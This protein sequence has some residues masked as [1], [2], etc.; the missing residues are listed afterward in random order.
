ML[1]YIWIFMILVGIFYGSI[2]GKL[3]NVSEA[4]LS[5]GAKTIALGITMLGVM[6]IWCGILQIAEDAGLMEKMVKKIRPLLHYLFPDI[7]RGHKAEEYIAVNLIANMLGL[8]SAATPAGLQ[9]MEQ[10]EAL[11]TEQKKEQA[12]YAM[13]TFLVLNISSLQL[14]P[15]NIIAY[16]MQYGSVTPYRIVGPG[17]AATFCS[18]CMALIF[19][20]IMYWQEFKRKSRKDM[21]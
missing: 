18:T 3:G 4:I 7:P 21:G 16:R 12:N 11:R 20:R 13:C 17:L 5:S 6:G 10:M 8:G 19:C 2:Q 9:A 1:N 14:I 15:I